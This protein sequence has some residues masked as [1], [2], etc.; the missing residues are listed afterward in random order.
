MQCTKCTVR[1]WLQCCGRGIDRARSCFNLLVDAIDC[2]LWR[3][4][5]TL[6]IDG[7]LGRAVGWVGSGGGSG[8]GSGGGSGGG[9]GCSWLR[10]QDVVWLTRSSCCCVMHLHTKWGFLVNRGSMTEMNYV[11]TNSNC[12]L[13][14]PS[15]PSAWEYLLGACHIFVLEYCK[16]VADAIMGYVFTI[17]QRGSLF[18]Q[19]MA[20][21]FAI[22]VADPA[23][24][25]SDGYFHRSRFDDVC[26][27][28]RANREYR[29][30]IAARTGVERY[31]SN[32]DWR[33]RWRWIIQS[34]L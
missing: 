21:N 3:Q 22:Y 30:E 1:L 20:D 6:M 19:S 4:H 28:W 12:K 29:V 15:L 18:Q 33:R 26:K 7:V 8:S 23:V 31:T 34:H 11:S 10:W 25:P 5:D 27:A 13:Y 2:D 17:N 9:V 14:T 24:L 16:G 32:T